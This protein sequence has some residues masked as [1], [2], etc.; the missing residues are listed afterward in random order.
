MTGNEY[1]LQLIN[2]KIASK[3]TD[4]IIIKNIQPLITTI[5]SWAGDCLI[6]IYFSGS[7]AKGTAVKGCSDIDLLI[8]LKSSTNNTLLEIYESL[9]DYLY[10]RNYTIRKQNVSLGVNYNGYS[11]DLVP[12]KKQEGNTN[13]HLLYSRKRKSWLK[14]NIKKHID[15]VVDSNRI[16]EI[17]IIK[18]WAQ[19]HNLDF[20]SIYLEHTVINSLKYK[21]NGNDYLAQNV[22]TVLQYISEHF[23]NSKVV[24]ISNTNNIISNDLTNNEK[25]LIVSQAQKSLNQQY[26]SNIVW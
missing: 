22:W 18:I 24:D 11:I 26:W 20:P 2:R 7:R 13:D 1:L 5:Q 19:V 15:F 6:N 8:S 14:T 17:K 25:L 9:Y 10:K 16:N 23:I 21:Y 3:D 4:S 12:A